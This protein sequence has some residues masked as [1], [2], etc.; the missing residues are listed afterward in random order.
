MWPDRVLRAAGAACVLTFAVV[1]GRAAA[2][3]MLDLHYPLAAVALAVSAGTFA[4][5]AVAHM[6]VWRM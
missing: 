6:I 5:A 1:F 3:M 4:G 2:M